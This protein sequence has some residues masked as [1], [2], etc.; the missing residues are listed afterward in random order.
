[1]QAAGLMRIAGEIMAQ[2]GYASGRRIAEILDRL[3]G[4][5]VLDEIDGEG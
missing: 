1:M 2:F 5:D 4:R 3:I